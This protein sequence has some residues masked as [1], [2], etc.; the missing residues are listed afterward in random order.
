MG[1][2]NGR[3]DTDQ[4]IQYQYSNGL[5]GEQYDNAYG[6]ART[7][8]KA[9]WNE[10]HFYRECSNKGICDRSPG[11]CACFPGFEGEGCRRITCPNSCSGHGQ[12][13]NMAVTNADYAAWDEKKTVECQCDPGYT[14]ADCSLRKCPQGT[15]PIA[16]V[17]TNDD[18]VYKIQW[19]QT[20]NKKWGTAEIPNGQVHW[21]MSYKDDF[22]DVWTTSAVT[23]YYQLRTT[24]GSLI[25]GPSVTSNLVATPFF[26]DPDF[27]GPATATV[28]VDGELKVGAT[29][30][31]S[32]VP[33]V[34]AMENSG[35]KKIKFS[36][37]PS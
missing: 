32:S 13:V 24:G 29:A 15:D 18:S 3:I 22:G 7:D 37:D 33:A 21:T 5:V 19:G 14:G 9:E 27:Q 28:S 10:A 23:T 34:Y 16:T 26:M 31:G 2:S 1:N 20:L 25:V 8:N 35:N 36:F 17:Y 30:K 4:Q 11:Q 6:L 12:C